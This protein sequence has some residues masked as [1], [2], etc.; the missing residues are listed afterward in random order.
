[1][2]VCNRHVDRFGEM[3]P[4]MQALY[5]ALE[6]LLKGDIMVQLVDIFSMFLGALTGLAFV[7]ATLMRWE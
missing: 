5:D 1:M 2:V 3:T 4:E 6:A 7:A